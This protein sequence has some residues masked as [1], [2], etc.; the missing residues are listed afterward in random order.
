MTKIIETLFIGGADSPYITDDRHAEIYRL[1]PL[2]DIEMIENC[3]HW[4]HAD[5]PGQ[6]VE[7][8]TDFLLTQP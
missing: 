6:F 7:L 4:V 1:F 8:C 5:K 3:G 2:A